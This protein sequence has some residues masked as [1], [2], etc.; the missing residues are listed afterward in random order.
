MQVEPLPEAKSFGSLGSGSGS[1]TLDGNTD[2]NIP[3]LHVEPLPEA[4]GVEHVIAAGQL[5]LR[6]VLQHITFMVINNNRR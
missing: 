5:R 1:T 6:H 4:D 3:H 2:S